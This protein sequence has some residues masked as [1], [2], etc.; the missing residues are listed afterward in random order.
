[1]AADGKTFVSRG[2][3]DN[4]LRVFDV[5]KGTEPKQIL[6]PNINPNAGGTVVFRGGF[7]TGGLPIAFSPDGQHVAA[8][9]PSGQLPNRGQTDGSLRIFDINTGKEI[10]QITLPISR[11]ISNL[12]YSPD[13]RVLA[14][15]NLDQTVG[16]WEIA[17]GRERGTIGDAF[18]GTQPAVPVFRIV[19]RPTHAAA[20]RKRA[21]V[22]ARW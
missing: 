12:T 16:L 17:S 4:T 6:L 7:T 20:H 19:G 18:A 2:N 14:T 8:S 22:F 10:R 13:G 21:G 9:L 1:M 11:T 3:A 5:A 15:E